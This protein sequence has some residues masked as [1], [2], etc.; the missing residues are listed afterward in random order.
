M[1]N[2]LYAVFIV[3]QEKNKIYAFNRKSK[4]FELTLNKS[5]NEDDFDYLQ[6]ARNHEPSCRNQ[7][8]YF[9]TAYSEAE[10]IRNGIIF[11]KHVP[12]PQKSFIDGF[13]ERLK[14]S[15]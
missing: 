8:Q 6:R 4:Q 15:V 1:S 3:R 2:K 9:F 14:I 10:Q 11:E 13:E 5:E 12:Y 7:P